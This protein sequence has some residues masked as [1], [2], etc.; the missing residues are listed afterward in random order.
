MQID[1]RQTAPDQDLPRYHHFRRR[2]LVPG[3]VAAPVER[4]VETLV[5]IVSAEGPVYAR[6]VFELYQRQAGGNRVRSDSR[7]A[8]IA[9]LD[10]AVADGHITRISDGL[11]DPVDKTLYLPGTDPVVVRSRGE[12][13]LEDI[14]RSEVATLADQ[15]GVRDKGSEQAMRAILRAYGVSFFDDRSAGYLGECLDY[16]WSEARP[17]AG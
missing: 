3:A 7:A 5:E 17:D 12:R 8:L 14:P 6:R 16:K 15:L 13:R 10:L 9:A 1:D 4:V 2:G 11:P